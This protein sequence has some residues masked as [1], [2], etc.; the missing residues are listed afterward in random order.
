MGFCMVRI[1]TYDENETHIG[2]EERDKVH[3]DGLWH[4]NVYV[5]VVSPSTRDI[6]L[7]LRD[8]RKAAYGGHWAAIGEHPEAGERD[9]AEVAMKGVK[10][11]MKLS[12]KRDKIIDLELQ[13]KVR[14][15]DTNALKD[16]EFQNYF[17][18]LWE[19]DPS[20]IKLGKENSEARFFRPYEIGESPCIVPLGNEYLGKVTKRLVKRGLIGRKDLR[21]PGNGGFFAGLIS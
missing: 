9:L 5:V 13:L 3:R 19:G 12:V 14:L 10:E 2:T 11:D 20:K 21:K 7:F 8:K 1:D 4:R 18:M 6:L 15:S 17:A 16:Y